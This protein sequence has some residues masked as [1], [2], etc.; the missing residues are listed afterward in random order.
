MTIQASI[1]N[2]DGEF[3]FSIVDGTA[4]VTSMRSIGTSFSETPLI[5][6]QPRLQ[7]SSGVLVRRTLQGESNEQKAFEKIDGLYEIKKTNEPVT[8]IL[9]GN[10][11]GRWTIESISDHSSESKPNATFGVTKFTVDLKE[12]PNDQENNR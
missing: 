7:A 11:L 8:L 9:A 6:G 5:Q 4:L 12:F 10:V 2:S 3:I 1:S